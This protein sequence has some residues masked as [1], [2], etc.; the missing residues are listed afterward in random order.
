MPR[1]T[2]T[3]STAARIFKDLV[4]DCWRAVA[5]V[6]RS[7]VVVGAGA[8]ADEGRRARA[9][10]AGRS[11]RLARTRLTLAELFGAAFC[12]RAF[13]PFCFWRA[14]AAR[15]FWRARFASALRR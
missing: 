11:S 3:A 10:D 2:S 7:A 14:A 1:A 13:F 15:C 6:D 5:V 8:S 4:V 9:G 12:G